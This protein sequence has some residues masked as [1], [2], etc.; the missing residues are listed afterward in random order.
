MKK[1]GKMIQINGIL[2]ERP[3]DMRGYQ[4]TCLSYS[5]CRILTRLYFGISSTE[6]GD[7]NELAALL[8]TEYDKVF[9]IVEVQLAF[10]HDY[11]FTTYHSMVSSPPGMLSV[12]QEV[13]TVLRDILA[14]M[15]VPCLRW[16]FGGRLFG[17]LTSGA[18]DLAVLAVEMFIVVL[19]DWLQRRPMLPM[20]WRTIF[21]ALKKYPEDTKLVYSP[22]VLEW[23]VGKTLNCLTPP[24]WQNKIGQYSLLEDYDR[25]D[26]MNTCEAQNHTDAILMWHITTWYCNIFDKGIISDHREA[27]TALSGYCAYLVAFLPEI[28]PG[29]SKNTMRVLQ[30]VLGQARRSDSLTTFQKGVKLGKQLNDPLLVELRWKVMAEFW[31]GTIL[32]IAP[33]DSKE[34]VDVHVDQLAQ[35]GEFLTHLWALLSIV[36]IQKQA[37]EEQIGP[38][39]EVDA[40]GIA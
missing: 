23:F 34:N 13:W 3:D 10:L 18:Q 37:R 39:R 30:S 6:E 31:A 8:P 2:K 14:Y 25:R 27:A 5:Y 40:L 12:A 21:N 7:P 22:T 1:D 15:A 17:G 19:V 26:H 36:G 4:D 20:Y 9:N 28:L 24:Y 33:S 16:L 32:Y 35:G 38:Q 29:E 11:C